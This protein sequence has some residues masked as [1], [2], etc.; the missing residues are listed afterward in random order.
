MKSLVIRAIELLELAQLGSALMIC[1]CTGRFQK[2]GIFSERM[3]RIREEGQAKWE[4]RK[5]KAQ[6]D[7]KEEKLRPWQTRDS[8][9][10]KFLFIGP[11]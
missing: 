4:R 9:L 7:I 5:R 8:E 1:V 2:S 11:P 10:S 6:L 3:E